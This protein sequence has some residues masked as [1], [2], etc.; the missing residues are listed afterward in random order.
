MNC[1]T[2]LF[3]LVKKRY[4][5]NHRLLTVLYSLNLVITFFYYAYFTCQTTNIL[6]ED[7]VSFAKHTEAL[8]KHFTE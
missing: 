2:F 4:G 1:G 7:N 3:L 5:F 8:I 6:N